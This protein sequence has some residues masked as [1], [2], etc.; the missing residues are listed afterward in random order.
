[1]K[2]RL[3]KEA[4]AP[5]RTRAEAEAIV[6]AV[7]DLTVE[8]LGLAADMDGRIL[9]I[10]KYFAPL[11]KRSNDE[12]AAAVAQLNGWANANPGE[13]G[14]AR[15]IEF[16]AGV[17]G[18]RTGQPQLKT[19]RGWDWDRVLQALKF[20]HQCGYIRVKE[21]VNK[22]ALLNTRVALGEDWLAFFGLKVSQAES[23]FVEP[24]LTPTDARATAA[25]S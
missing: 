24:K 4:V 15:S 11:L 20:E 12:L 3:K 21:E 7:A 23:F 5:I 18:W 1:M 13:F 19:Q 10:K 22:E 16:P 8:K 25:K 17:I 9:S 2:T 14:K 6:A